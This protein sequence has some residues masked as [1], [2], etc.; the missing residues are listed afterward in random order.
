MSTEVIGTVDHRNAKRVVRSVARNRGKYAFLIGA[1]TSYGADIPLASD[2]ID[3]CKRKLYIENLAGLEVEC[4]NPDIGKYE[5][6][7]GEDADDIHKWVNDYRTKK[8]EDHQGE[9]GFWMSEC[10]TTREE[11]RQFIHNQFAD[12]DPTFG[13]IMLAGLMNAKPPYVSHVLTPNFD[14]LLYDAFYEYFN[15]RPRLLTHNA[16]IGPEFK[17]TGSDPAIIKLHGDYLYSNLQNTALETS[18]LKENMRNAVHRTLQEYGLVVVG[19]SGRD[20]SIMDV[21]TSEEFTIPEPGIIWCARDR[22][23]LPHNVKVLLRKPNTYLAEIEGFEELMADFYR[24]VRDAEGFLFPRPKEMDDRMQKL[25]HKVVAE[26]KETRGGSREAFNPSTENEDN[27][28]ALKG[29]RY[30]LEGRYWKEEKQDDYAEARY[31]RAI[32]A[33]SGDPMNYIALAE[34]YNDNER[35]FEQWILAEDLYT[36]AMKI[37]CEETTPKENLSTIDLEDSKVDLNTLDLD[38]LDDMR[39]YNGRGIVRRRIART[40]MHLFFQLDEMNEEGFGDYLSGV[41]E[42]EN[43]EDFVDSLQEVLED[44]NDGALGDYLIEALEEMD[45][46]EIADSM[47]EVVADVNDETLIDTMQDVLEE[48]N[49]EEVVNLMIEV[50]EDIDDGTTISMQEVVEKVND[51]RVL[52]ILQDLDEE[53]FDEYLTLLQ[54]VLES[55]LVGSLQNIVRILLDEKWREAILDFQWAVDRNSDAYVPYLSKGILCFR[56]ALFY[57]KIGDP[58]KAMEQ[59]QMSQTCYEQSAEH[60]SDEAIPHLSLAEV[61]FRL[62]NFETTSAEAQKA[63]TMSRKLGNMILANY[64]EFLARKARYQNMDP[65]TVEATRL[66]QEVDHLEDKIEDRITDGY[67]IKWVK[68]AIDHVITAVQNETPSRGSIKDQY[69]ALIPGDEGREDLVEEIVESVRNYLGEVDVD[70]K[71]KE[72]FLMVEEDGDG[73]VEVIT[74]GGAAVFHEGE[75]CGREINRGLEGVFAAAN[76]DVDIFDEGSGLM[77]T[78]RDVGEVVD[79]TELDVDVVTES[80]YLILF[81]DLTD[82]NNP[83]D[84]VA[85]ANDFVAE[86]PSGENHPVTDNEDGINFNEEIGIDFDDARGYLENMFDQELD[87]PGVRDNIEPI[88]RYI[89]KD[90]EADEVGDLLGVDDG[91]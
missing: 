47:Q 55:N 34:Y 29:L 91:F 45:D 4:Q 23:N 37:P 65:S 8:M 18:T 36:V 64:F 78:S 76:A 26:V 24:R 58:V 16:I 67:E 7:I 20:D 21:L 90:V 1:G 41:L 32:E 53:N 14:D 30:R 52:N 80:G 59:Y 11:R 5:E 54:E 70:V 19:Y 83:F 71:I 42:E 75:V 68:K 57:E 13:H 79:D 62:K 86:L 89:G 63:A 73:K 48:A 50:L 46:S 25:A 27:S 72:G 22:N 74:N 12:A 85:T 88:I 17:L 56:R 66:K 6:E 87:L 15:E 2:L 33:D 38:G 81:G 84:D 51:E 28:S 40:L 49:N 43:S 82:P 60:S 61:A 10:Y 9:Y 31:K 35:S 77:F 39:I 44:V 3:R 69:L